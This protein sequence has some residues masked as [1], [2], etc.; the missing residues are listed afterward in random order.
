MQLGDARLGVLFSAFFWTYA[1]MQVVA[2][3]FIDRC[4]VVPVF[5]VG[6]LFWSAATM[7]TGF[8]SSFGTLLAMRLLL[9]VGESVAYPAYARII[10]AGFPKHRR[11]TADA[12]T[13]AGSRMGPALA[14]LAGGALRLACDV[15]GDLRGRAALA[16]RVAA[17]GGARSRGA[18]GPARDR[19]RSR[20]HSLPAA[21]LG[22]FLRALLPQLHLVFRLEL[23][24]QLSDARALLHAADDGALRRAAVLGHRGR[25]RAVR[26]GV[27]PY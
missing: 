2:G 10:A 5:T 21:G 17:R 1:S 22:H 4:G 7:L 14:V 13:D 3:Y 23:A 6:F 19:P 12:L 20:R 24:A 9:G 26:R 25:L 18:P 16:G 11:G 27:G 8:A 15:P